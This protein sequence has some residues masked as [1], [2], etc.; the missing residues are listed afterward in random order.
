MHRGCRQDQ[1]SKLPLLPELI[2]LNTTVSSGSNVGT[3]AVPPDMVSGASFSFTVTATQPDTL[4]CIGSRPMHVEYV[5][6]T[7]ARSLLLP[8]NRPDTHPFMLHR[9]RARWR[10]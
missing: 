10:C 2:T 9:A 4:T 6:N 1:I 8:C 3:S 5:S 7:G